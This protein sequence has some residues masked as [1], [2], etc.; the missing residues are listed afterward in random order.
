MKKNN[1]IITSF[2]CGILRLVSGYYYI[3]QVVNVLEILR[4]LKK[5]QSSEPFLYIF[6]KF[7]VYEAKNNSISIFCCKNIQLIQAC[8]T[9]NGTWTIEN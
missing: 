9:L 8:Q 7:F 6:L 2:R 4:K 1:E 3:N 5:K